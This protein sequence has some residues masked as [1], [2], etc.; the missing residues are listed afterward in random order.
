MLESPLKVIKYS[1][2]ISFYANTLLFSLAFSYQSSALLECSN[3]GGPSLVAKSAALETRQSGFETWLCHSPAHV[4]CSL[5][6]KF[7]L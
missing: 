2:N 3:E 7:P 6:L 4:I 5:L 1:L